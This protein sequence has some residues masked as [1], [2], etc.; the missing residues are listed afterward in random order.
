MALS[1]RL[2]SSTMERAEA[3]RGHAIDGPNPIDLRAPTKSEDLKQKRHRKIKQQPSPHQ[4][5]HN[6]ITQTRT[7]NTSTKKY[8]PELAVSIRRFFRPED[9]ASQKHEEEVVRR[10][11]RPAP[12][13]VPLQV[14][15]HRR[16][17]RPQQLLRL[18]RHELIWKKPPG[19]RTGAT[20]LEWRWG[21]GVK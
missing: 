16:Q 9:L 18:I 4:Q 21:W 20:G 3:T 10:G 17:A 19:G 2:L 11:R 15:T 7:Q 14:G 13:R 6:G 1:P 8:L 12:G 5:K